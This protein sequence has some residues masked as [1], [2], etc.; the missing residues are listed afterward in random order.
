M[1]IKSLINEDF[2]NFCLP[3]M[4]IVTSKCSFQCDKEYG[5]YICQKFF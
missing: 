3:A 2:V 1:N 4:F 5:S